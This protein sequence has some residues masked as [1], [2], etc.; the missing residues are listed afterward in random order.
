MQSSFR[1]NIIVTDEKPQDQN[2]MQL[3]NEAESLKSII[4]ALNQKMSSHDDI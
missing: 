4:L 3:K 1:K 2:E